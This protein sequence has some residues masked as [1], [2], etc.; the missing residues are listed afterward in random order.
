MADAAGRA[1]NMARSLD[2]PSANALLDGLLGAAPELDAL[3]AHVLRHT[4]QVP[5]FIEEVARQ[6]VN[7]GILNGDAGRFATKA[8][9]DALEIPPTVQGVIASRIDRLAKEDKALLQLASV[10]GPRVSTRLLGAVTGMPAA[11][12][13]SRLWSLEILDFLVRVAMACLPGT[14]ICP[15]SH[16]RSCLSFDPAFAARTA[17]LADIDGSGGGFCRT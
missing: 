10:V 8:P 3:K 6:L 5:L 16:S 14:R 12:L 2:I 17:A 9:W 13:Q 11:Q 4:G 7:R 15:R 1:Q